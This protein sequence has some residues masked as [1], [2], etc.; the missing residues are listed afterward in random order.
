MREVELTRHAAAGLRIGVLLLETRPPARIVTFVSMHAVPAAS[1]QLLTLSTSGSMKNESTASRKYGVAPATGWPG[2]AHVTLSPCT[3][4][5]VCD[6]VA[7]T[8]MNG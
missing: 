6:V 8:P 7:Y 3:P 4:A 2:S 5:R 1:V